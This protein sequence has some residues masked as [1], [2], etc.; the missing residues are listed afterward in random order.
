[1]SVLFGPSALPRL[2]L[3]MTSQCP[4]EEEN[5]TLCCPFDGCDGIRLYT[6]EECLLH[7]HQ[8]HH[9]PYMCA[10][11]NFTAVSQL[12]L[13]RH[14]ERAATTSRW[15][16]ITLDARSRVLEPESR[17]SAREFTRLAKN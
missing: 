15:C 2:R 17:L 11:C 13:S 6:M 10:H 8:L 14:A 4:N 7:D 1:M 3:Y 9:G 16:A 12:G 5:E